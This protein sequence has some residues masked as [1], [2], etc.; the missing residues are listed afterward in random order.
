[1]RIRLRDIEETPKELVFDEPTGELNPRLKHGPVHDYEFL[2]PA[3]IHLRHY[4]SGQE[5]FFTATMES[6]VAGECARC[7]NHFEFR[8]APAFE[9]VMVPRSGRWAEEDLDDG[10]DDLVWYDGDDVDISPLLHER[11]L[12]TLPTLPLCRDDCRGLCG[13]CGVDL[14]LDSCECQTET[15]DPRLAVLRALRRE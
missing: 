1:M 10:G 15:G 11:L 14:N 6:R 9:I 2:G 4:R 12:L 7:L 3:S 5:L 8:H 13:R